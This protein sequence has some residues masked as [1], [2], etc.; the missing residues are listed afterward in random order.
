[1]SMLLFSTAACSDELDGLPSDHVKKPRCG[2]S[3]T[4]ST[5][6]DKDDNLYSLE[7]GGMGDTIKS[8]GYKGFVECDTNESDT[9][10]AEFSYEENSFRE[11]SI[12]DY[13]EFGLELD[14]RKIFSAEEWLE[15]E[16]GFGLTKSDRDAYIALP[17]QEKKFE[18]TYGGKLSEKHTGEVFI[19]RKSE[20]YESGELDFNEENNSYAKGY[21]A[22]VIY[23]LGG[24]SSVE[25][26]YTTERVEYHNS[27]RLDEDG[28]S[29]N[30]PRRD[31]NTTFAVS[32]TKVYSLYPLSLLMVSSEKSDNESTSNQ[33]YDWYERNGSDFDYMYKI[34]EGFDDYDDFNWSVY[35][36]R[37]L[38]SRATG[39][40][41]YM[42]S[43]TGYP[44]QYIDSGDVVMPGTGLEMEMDYAMVGIEYLLNENA[45]LDISSSRIKNDSNLEYYEY[46]K[47]INSVGLSY[48]F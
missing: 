40:L 24:F 36:L 45:K 18:F 35:Y 7:S 42:R 43:E 9:F 23:D 44:R 12:E 30:T 37:G 8:F 17:G 2:I 33:Y 5:G 19:F 13:R 1:M 16:Y 48:R 22:R 31:R 41:Y 46:T 10:T 21:G 29:T 32:V 25:V 15:I 39:F 11:N 47:R 4:F 14:Y 3:H 20:T 38:S 34:T 26:S 6:F 27:Y 28:N